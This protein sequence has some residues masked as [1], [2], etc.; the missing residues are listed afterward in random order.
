MPRS[1][2][3]LLAA[4]VTHGGAVNEGIIRAFLASPNSLER[5]GMVTFDFEGTLDILVAKSFLAKAKDVIRTRHDSVIEIVSRTDRLQATI[6]ALEGA[7]KN[8][9]ELLR[10]SN[11]DFF[12]STAEVLDWL[13]YFN[14]RLEDTVGTLRCLEDIGRLSFNSVA[15]RRLL[16]YA[17]H[18]AGSNPWR[19]RDRSPNQYGKTTSFWCLLALS[20]KA[21]SD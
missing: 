17:S 20:I 9:Y 14:A 5:L 3:T 2:Q 19:L 11:G 16:E 8:F 1:E 4:V 15:P 12:L 21:D 10:A 6:I 7:W 18:T 13:T